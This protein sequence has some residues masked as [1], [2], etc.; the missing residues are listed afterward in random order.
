MATST[1][2]ILPQPQAD[3]IG[4][5]LSASPLRLVTTSQPL[6]ILKHIPE[7]LKKYKL[8]LHTQARRFNNCQKR[9]ESFVIT[10]TGG[11]I[12][13]ECNADSYNNIKDAI[14]TYYDN[15]KSFDFQTCEKRPS[16]EVNNITVA[17]MIR[18]SYAAG[19]K[20]YT[21]NLYHTS[22]SLL[23]NGKG[24]HRFV[25]TDWPKII[26]DSEHSLK[27]NEDMNKA[28][29][30][31]KIKKK[32]SQAISPQ[33]YI[34]GDS[35][36]S[37]KIMAITEGNTL[38]A[39]E[40]QTVPGPAPDSEDIKSDDEVT[41]MTPCGPITSEIQTPNG[42]IDN[43]N[44]DVETTII[45]VNDLADENAD[46]DTTLMKEKCTATG[47]EIKDSVEEVTALENV[48][49][50]TDVDTTLLKQRLTDTETEI[51]V[52]NGEEPVQEQ[53]EATINVPKDNKE[54]DK[55]SKEIANKKEDEENKQKNI[56]NKLDPVKVEISGKESGE[57]EKK[58]EVTPKINLVNTP[59]PK[60]KKS[61]LGRG[62]LMFST[63]RF[64]DS[65]NPDEGKIVRMLRQ[66]NGHVAQHSD[67]MSSL[68]K[69]IDSVF[70]YAKQK[71]KYLEKEISDLKSKLD[72]E[73]Q[74]VRDDIVSK[75]NCNSLVMKNFK[76]EAN[77]KLNSLETKWEMAQTV[78]KQNEQ[79]IKGL[80]TKTNRLESSTMEF[81]LPARV[82]EVEGKLSQVSEKVNKSM[83]EKMDEFELRLAEMECYTQNLKVKTI[84]NKNGEPAHEMK[85]KESVESNSSSTSSSIAQHRGS[86]S[87]DLTSRIVAS[88]IE[89]FQKCR[90][91][92]FCAEI[93]SRCQADE[94]VATVNTVY[95]DTQEATHST[96]AY[97]VKENEKLVMIADDDGENGG[98]G[99][100][101]NILNDRLM[102]NVIVM[103]C[104]WHGGEK[105]HKDRWRVITQVTTEVLDKISY[106]TVTPK[107]SKQD[108]H[109]NVRQETS[110]I[111]PEGKTLYLCDSTGGM[112]YV[113][114]LLNGEPGDKKSAP[115]LDTAEDTLKNSST[116]YGKIIIQTGIN[117]L[118]RKNPKQVKDSIIRIIETC[119][120]YQPKAAIYICSILPYRGED[121]PEIADINQ[122]I[123]S[124]AM[125]TGVIFIDTSTEFK[126]NTN[127][128]YDRV[129]PNRFGLGKLV[130]KIK[131]KLGLPRP[132]AT[133][134]T[135]FRGG[136][137]DDKKKK[138]PVHTSRNTSY[139]ENQRIKGN[140]RIPYNPWLSQSHKPNLPRL[141]QQNNYGSSYNSRQ[142]GLGYRFDA[143]AD[144]HKGNANTGYNNR[145]GGHDDR[146]ETSFDNPRDDARTASNNQEYSGYSYS[147][148]PGYG[149]YSDR[150]GETY[151]LDQD[152]YRY[153]HTTY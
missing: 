15:Y 60:R 147:T 51:K 5:L 82:T 122:A 78:A 38:D 49:D 120:T 143:N 62:K 100:V 79:R 149:A 81:T 128:Y 25:T 27:L 77:Q 73:N 109:H 114:K 32:S 64:S 29:T 31:H 117:D 34:E 1:L 58:N 139:M 76:S 97:I 84:D 65:K 10:G 26:L 18:I 88:K 111:T 112:V 131:D 127:W 93:T 145:Q 150:W 2:S 20:C 148:N 45:Y 61:T 47:A 23:I 46:E 11:G 41:F 44:A 89:Q 17:D 54:K 4:A 91:Q 70:T 48:I 99:R 135:F 19:T 108:S 105:I 134:T 71:V 152:A 96:T 52:N 146:Y 69:K 42:S 98:G 151:N 40:Q 74:K 136:Q 8:D 115:T 3:S 68:E 63:P 9:P 110:T 53:C 85:R 140:D 33:I 101:M 67:K 104:R 75:T 94:F 14:T 153:N 87:N 28:L 57:M 132:S 35:I 50:S 118:K 83:G 141:V 30:E 119:K 12:T 86:E 102:T 92:A 21:I 90:F 80:E 124:H 142:D 56:E 55:A 144:S 59:T 113:S 116:K 6:Q 133:S 121:S 106:T 13:V 107:H 95:E 123:E 72:S 129:H 24:I 16:K 22:C 36:T 66:I 130:R 126:R 7:D 43:D 103:V 125:R 137:E 39:N 37:A 138:A